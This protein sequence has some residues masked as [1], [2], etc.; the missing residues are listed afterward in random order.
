MTLVFG[1]VG[2]QAGNGSA[3]AAGVGFLLAGLFTAVP[4]SHRR[5]GLAA[6]VAVVVGVA[7]LVAG[8]KVSSIDSEPQDAG[9]WL[10]RVGGAAL[11]ALG[12]AAFG[13]LPSAGERDGA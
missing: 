1:P 13:R 12:G 2:L 4:R 3:L 9:W 5:G 7:L 11:I 10:H 6:L 8:W